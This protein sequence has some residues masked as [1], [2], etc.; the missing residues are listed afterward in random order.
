LLDPAI[1]TGNMSAADLRAFERDRDSSRLVF[2]P[3]A[4]PTRF[5]LRPLSKSQQLE[6]AGSS[7]NDAT[8]FVRAFRYAVVEVKGARDDNGATFTF[9]P[10][11]TK[12]GINGDELENGPFTVPQMIDIGSVAWARSFLVPGNA[13]H[14][15]A[16][17]SLREQWEAR[18]CLSAE[19]S[20]AR[21]SKPKDSEAQA[22]MA[23][24]ET[25]NGAPSALP[26]VAPATAEICHSAA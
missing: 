11:D 17:P 25:N 1:D 14:C 3:G 6:I 18:P 16:H 22:S 2:K 8:N 24:A 20:A 23:P 7:S 4:V 13:Q 5:M 15:V 19:Q 9:A 10:A 21:T 26:T 12:S